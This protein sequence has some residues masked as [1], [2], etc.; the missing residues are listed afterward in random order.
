MS[1]RVDS[2][3]MSCIQLTPYSEL[4]LAKEK[5]T[6]APDPEAQAEVTCPALLS[7]G[8]DPASVYDPPKSL[9]VRRP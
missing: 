8:L 7:S 9:Q 6:E 2:H 3:V 1:T 4:G 5:V